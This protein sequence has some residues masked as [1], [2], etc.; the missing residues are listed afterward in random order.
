[1]KNNINLINCRRKW[2]IGRAVPLRLMGAAKSSVNVRCLHLRRFTRSTSF[3]NFLT[4]MQLI[5]SC[6]CIASKSVN[7]GNSVS[8]LRPISW[9]PDPC[10]I[11][12]L[13]LTQIHYGDIRLR[14]CRRWELGAPCIWNCVRCSMA[15]VRQRGSRETVSSS[16]LRTERKN[17]C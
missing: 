10:K 4:E 16:R 9:R 5:I 12:A 15:N 14:R 11:H 1:M 3:M 8:V 2:K 13:A 7:R 17:Y 6:A